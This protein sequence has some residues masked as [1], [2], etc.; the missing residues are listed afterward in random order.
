MAAPGDV[1]SD[2][3]L[4]M[5]LQAAELTSAHGLP[6]SAAMDLSST[7]AAWPAWQALVD[8]EVAV[9]A[10]TGR[11]AA[12]AAAAAEGSAAAPRRLSLSRR[13][14]R[15]RP[16]SSYSARSGG[17]RAHVRVGGNDDGGVAGVGS[18]FGGP[19]DTLLGLLSSLTGDIDIEELGEI[20]RAHV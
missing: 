16:A 6:R 17:G 13:P 8:A 4:A 19:F 10:V 3:A 20:G 5:D 7:P 12:A 18:I 11:A 9:H 1:A 2:A 15:P 14:S